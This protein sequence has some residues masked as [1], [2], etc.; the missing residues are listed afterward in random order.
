MMIGQSPAVRFHLPIQLLSSL[1]ELRQAVAPVGGFGGQLE[2]LVLGL[3]QLLQDG[4]SLPL[5]DLQLLLGLW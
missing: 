1:G 3:G 5:A 4:L 2:G